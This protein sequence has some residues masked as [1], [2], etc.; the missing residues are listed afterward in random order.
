MDS[1]TILQVSENVIRKSAEMADKDPHGLIITLV[2]VSVVFAALILLYFAYTLIGM[3][4]NGKL[5]LKTGKSKDNTGK[6]SDEV[7]AAIAM[8]LQQELNGEIYAAIGLA[9]HQHF[10]DS[11]H[12]EESY[13]ITIRRQEYE[14]I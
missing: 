13:I 2:S 3:M 4:T 10:N 5:S 14:R 11:V 1:M 7:V 12:D 8:A 9:L 6:P